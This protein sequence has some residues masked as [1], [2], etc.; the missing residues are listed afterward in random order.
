MIAAFD[1]NSDA[2]VKALKQAIR[3]GHRSPWFLDDPIFDE[4][5]SNPGFIAVRQELDAILED[6][7]NKTLQM[8]CFKNPVPDTWQPLPET[9]AGVVEQ[10][11][12]GNTSLGD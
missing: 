2:A 3:N 10:T 12:P 4:M 8:I 6:E 7:H 5:R 1:G 9:C 11:T